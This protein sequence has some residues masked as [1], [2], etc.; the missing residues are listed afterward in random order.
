[1]VCS[2][3]GG[4]DPYSAKHLGGSPVGGQPICGLTG[5]SRHPVMAEPSKGK[6]MDF[7][8]P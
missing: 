6:A 7:E 4:L 3:G 2:P 8:N 5:N 1:M